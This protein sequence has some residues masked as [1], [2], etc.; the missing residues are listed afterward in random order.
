MCEHCAELREQIRE[1]ERALEG[2]IWLVEPEVLKLRK[3][4]RLTDQQARIVALVYKAGAL[5]STQ[6]ALGLPAYG[7]R[8]SDDY[9]TRSNTIRTQVRA[10]R[11]RVGSYCIGRSGNKIALTPEF[12]ERV[13]G[14]LA[15]TL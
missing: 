6:I 2:A 15:A 5:S 9:G 1:L 11:K 10:V 12:R 4:F 8:V 13:R 3:A 14:A 7:G